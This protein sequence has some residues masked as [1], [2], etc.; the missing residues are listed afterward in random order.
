MRRSLLI[1]IALCAAALAGCGNF[2]RVAYNNGDTALRFMAN[3]YF[4]IDPAQ[5]EI[6]RAGLDRFHTWHRREELPRYAALFDDASS[7]LGRGLQRTDVLWAIETV[8][9]R[10]RHLASRA[11]DDAM[12]ALVTLNADNLAALEEKFAEKNKEFRREFLDGDAAERERAQMKAYRKR[13]DEWVGNLEPAQEELTLQFIRAHPKAA[14]LKLEERKRRQQ[15]LIALLRQPGDR[16]QFQAR[17]HDYF[18]R[19][20]R[21]RPPEA[22]E[23]ARRFE[24][25]F[26]DYM[27]AMDRSLSPAQRDRVT[28]KFARYAQDFRMLATEGRV[29]GDA[30]VASN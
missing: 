23:A 14:E 26:V 19:F 2:V 29:K 30:S 5:T 21:S 20:E 3:D 12:P 1:S 10:Y 13:L 8:R 6:L 24:N 7:R 4:D 28:Q 27:V 9:T 16:A 18:E 22:A 15:Q 11:V 25:D 17:M